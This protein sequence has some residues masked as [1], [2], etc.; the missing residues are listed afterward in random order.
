MAT[1][2]EAE[3][4]E[5]TLEATLERTDF[6]HIINENK[7]PILIIGGIIL[8]LIAGYSIMETVQ[9]NKRSEKLDSLFKVEDT[10]F[11]AYND[12]K[13]D[14]NAF[15]T[16]FAGISN[17]FQAEPNLVPPMLKSINKL[18]TNKALDPATLDKVK[19]WLGKMDK[20]NYLYLFAAIRVAAIYEDHNQVNE[21]ISLL[22]GLIA[23]K[24]DFML[25]KIHFDLGR[26]YKENGD[27]EKAKSHFNSVVALEQESEFKS[28][29]KIYLGEL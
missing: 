28:I 10:V 19:A 27:K 9:S 17:E 1:N 8:L 29:A 3:S 23:N 26:F 14:D 5:K 4:I 2:Q 22:E 18:E 15:K 12:G 6:G 20:K 21:S 16:A 24:A 11:N 7:K 13:I 25:D